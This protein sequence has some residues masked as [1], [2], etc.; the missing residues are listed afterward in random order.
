MGGNHS[1][2]GHMKFEVTVKHLRRDVRIKMNIRVRLQVKVWAGSRSVR[3]PGIWYKPVQER[4]T[5]RYSSGRLRYLHT[6]EE[7]PA[8]QTNGKT[9]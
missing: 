2:W 6:C 8:R 5:Q 7:K 1:V 4:R 9:S 3:V